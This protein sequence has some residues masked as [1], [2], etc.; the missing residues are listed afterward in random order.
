MKK[1]LNGQQISPL[2]KQRFMALE[3]YVFGALSISGSDV[4][5]MENMV[6]LVNDV[7][8][9]GVSYSGRASADIDS[10]WGYVTGLS[11]SQRKKLRNKNLHKV[12]YP[13]KGAM[14]SKRRAKLAHALFQTP[15]AA[16]ERKTADEKVLAKVRQ[17]RRKFQNAAPTV[18]AKDEF[19][20][21]WEWRTT[22]MEVLKEHGRACQCCGA[23][24]GMKTAAGDPV[25]ICV[26]HIKP[27]SL[28]WHLR[29]EKSNLQVLCDECNQGKGNWDQTDFR[30][31]APDEWVTEESEVDP[32]I[33]A[34]LADH[35]GRLQ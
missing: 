13:M 2:H 1:F 23:E 34:Q 31:S 26:D 14:G 3:G 10:M 35:T 4:G 15:S 6:A 5:T 27:L 21:S 30:P 7:F 16:A 33:L 11:K 18:A 24:P 22:R 28:F 9:A 17:P 8:E 25:R 32:A 12:P 19:Y 20:N 29:L